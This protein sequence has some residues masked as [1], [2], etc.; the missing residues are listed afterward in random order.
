MRGEHMSAPVT[1]SVLALQH[2]SYWAVTFIAFPAWMWSLIGKGK[3]RE[4]HS[5]V[6]DQLYGSYARGRQA[7]DLARIVG[8]IGLSEEERLYLKF[9]DEFESRFI[10]QGGSE[11]RTIEQTLDLAWQLLNILP[12]DALTRIH[13]DY[14]RKYYKAAKH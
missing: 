6:A 8:E 10:K 3:T 4:D 2:N 7:R 9:A 12:E 1:I 13:E 14:I 5:N 11:N